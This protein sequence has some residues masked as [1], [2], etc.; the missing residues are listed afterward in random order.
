MPILTLYASPEKMSSDLFCAFQPKRETVPFVSVA[1]HLASDGAS[2]HLEIGASFD[3][4]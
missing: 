4:Q 3:A 2:N 1:V